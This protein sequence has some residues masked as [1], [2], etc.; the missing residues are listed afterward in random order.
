[1]ENPIPDPAPTE[2]TSISTDD[3]RSLSK[4]VSAETFSTA[5]ETSESECTTVD[6]N[7]STEIHTSKSLDVINANLLDEQQQRQSEINENFLMAQ[8]NFKAALRNRAKVMSL[9]LGI[10]VK[11]VPKARTK[12]GLHDDG[13][14]TEAQRNRLRVM[15]SEFGIEIGDDVCR[16]SHEGAKKTQLQMNKDR[17]M[18]SN[19]C[20]YSRAC[21]NANFINQNVEA[22]TERKPKAL[23]LDLTIEQPPVRQTQ[24]NMNVAFEITVS[25]QNWFDTH[26]KKVSYNY[27]VCLMIN[28]NKYT[29]EA[30]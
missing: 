9:E 24:V 8:E 15:S 19:E 5:M 21:D 2:V 23:T 3:F 26:P 12:Y 16:K 25:N 18:A 28:Q 20:F 7:A 1:M 22:E 10:E 17:M 14:L 13:I 27:N 29:V 4:S 30:R 6:E 11:N